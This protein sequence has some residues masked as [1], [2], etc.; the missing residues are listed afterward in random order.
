MHKVYANF[1]VYDVSDQ[2]NMEGCL[3]EK[4]IDPSSLM[5]DDRKI[6]IREFSFV[7][8]GINQGDIVLIDGKLCTLIDR[9][10]PKDEHSDVVQIL[11]YRELSGM[12]EVDKIEAA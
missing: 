1:T 9:V 5:P 6:I 12:C 10:F 7:F 3:S 2:R 8:T 11:T 4:I